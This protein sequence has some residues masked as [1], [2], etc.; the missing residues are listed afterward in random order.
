MSKSEP[1]VKLNYSQGWLYPGDWY[2]I[3]NFY[4]YHTTWVIGKI[5]SIDKT[6]DYCRVAEILDLAKPIKHPRR[7]GMAVQAAYWSTQNVGP[8]KRRKVIKDIF[9]HP[10]RLNWYIKYKI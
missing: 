8:L 5:I 2:Y 6:R 10:K 4:L 3:K 9:R 1:K 7:I